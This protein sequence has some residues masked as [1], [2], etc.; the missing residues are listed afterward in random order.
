MKKR[1]FRSISQ[2]L[3]STSSEPDLELQNQRLDTVIFRGS[4][5]PTAVDLGQWFS[6]KANFHKTIEATAHSSTQALVAGIDNSRRVR[7]SRDEKLQSNSSQNALE[8]SGEL[9][10]LLPSDRSG[11]ACSNQ[12]FEA[13]RSKHFQNDEPD[14]VRFSMPSLREILGVAWRT[15][16]SL[17]WFTAPSTSAI[18]ALLGIVLSVVMSSLGL[19][20]TFE[21]AG[22]SQKISI[23]A[24]SVFSAM[25]TLASFLTW[26]VFGQRT[27]KRKLL[28]RS[29]VSVASS[30]PFFFAAVAFSSMS[31]LTSFASLTLTNQGSSIQRQVNSELILPIEKLQ[32]DFSEMA[33]AASAVAVFSEKRVAEELAVGGTCGGSF[34]GSGPIANLR[35]DLAREATSIAG[36]TMQLSEKAISLIMRVSSS[37]SQREINL[38]FNEARRLSQVAED[39]RIS[40]WAHVM[41]AGYSD[42]GFIRDGQVVLCPDMEMIEVLDT[43]LISADTV[44][45]M[46]SLTPPARAAG[47]I[48]VF[49]LSY[50]A[51]A[52]TNLSS[53]HASHF[54]FYA[55]PYLFFA[56][57]VELIIGFSAVLI[58]LRRSSQL[59]GKQFEAVRRFQWVLSNFLLVIDR[60]SKDRKNDQSDSASAHLAYLM[61]PHGGSAAI[62]DDVEWIASHYDLRVDPQRQYIQ[63][64]TGLKEP[65]FFLERLRFASRGATHIS[66][67]PIF[68]ARLLA[69]IEKDLSEA[70][71]ALGTISPSRSVYS[72]LELEI[73]KSRSAKLKVARSG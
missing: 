67:Y 2:R 54:N 9:H 17:L 46:P 68:S 42:N 12:D 37:A 21:Q 16:A 71:N 61:L 18:M 23:L 24:G 14:K 36:I 41:R 59:K 13:V 11:I 70:T 65:K 34:P 40:Q 29:P 56:L 43:L 49:A 50:G 45:R 8:N 30:F 73:G 53:Q 47:I 20:I 7:V 27:G 28:R 72:K 32:R 48:D 22:L 15:P 4:L 66:A 58:G 33:L 57:L 60:D 31:A 62:T 51:I 64:G 35:S 52:G 5:E 6:L 63:L 26:Q 25:I 69:M 55:T 19:T 1:S 38:A 39:A 10:D 3:K 44:T